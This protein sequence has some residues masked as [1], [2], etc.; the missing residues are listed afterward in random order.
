MHISV[1]STQYTES[2]AGGDEFLREKHAWL[3]YPKTFT[4][5]LDSF[6]TPVHEEAVSSLHSL[7]DADC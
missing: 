1:I 3:Y 6:L 7:I 4:G 2:D 5:R